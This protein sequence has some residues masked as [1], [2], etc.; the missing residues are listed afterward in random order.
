MIRLALAVLLLLPASLSAQ[1]RKNAFFFE[2]GG[3]AGYGSANLELGLARQLR[4]RAGAGF[5]YVWPT[6]PLTGS[7]LLGHGPNALEIGAG[8][9]L[10]KTP[11]QIGDQ[12]PTNDFL[13]KIL[14]AEGQGTMVMTTGVI[15]WRYQPAHG[16][17]I[18]VA[19][20]PLYFE[21]DL[22]FW[23]G[24]SLGFSF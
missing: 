2:F 14:F 7:L 10:I 18:R 20:T 23:G 11:D 1:V 19:M 6:F 15:G 21:G 24:A 4:V 12:D 8:V 22:A 9:T 16:A 5:M 13:E 17:M 3:P